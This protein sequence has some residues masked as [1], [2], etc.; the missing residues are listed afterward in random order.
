M[1]EIEA[2]ETYEK[3]HYGL[4]DK[5]RARVVAT[6]EL[7]K[8]KGPLLSRPFADTVRGS[9]F[10]HMKE[11]RIQS[12]GEPLRVFFAF[13]PSRSSIL[14]CGGNKAENEKRFYEVMVAQADHE[15]TEYLN[16]LHQ[17]R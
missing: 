9:R 3:W 13:S 15:Y 4:S 6:L 7:L 2:T 12:H 5:Q 16:N 17:S 1:W 14:L 10:S 11:L 8:N